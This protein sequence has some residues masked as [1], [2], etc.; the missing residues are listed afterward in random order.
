MTDTCSNR[1]QRDRPSPG[2]NVRPKDHSQFSIPFSDDLII[3][4]WHPRDRQA[5]MQVIST[6][7]SEYGLQWDPVHADHDVIDVEAAYQHGEFWLVENVT[8]AQIVGTAAF[9]PVPKRGDSVVEIRK[10]YLDTSVRRLGLGAFLLSALEQR[11]L[12]LGY[13]TVLV[14]TA[15][16]LK[17]ACILYERRGYLPSTGIDTSRCDR[18]FEKQLLATPSE[19]HDLVEIVDQTRGWSIVSMPRKQAIKYHLPYRA[20]VIQVETN[21]KILVHKRSMRKLTY[22][23]K[24]SAVVTGCVDWGESIHT[25]ACRKISEE[26]GI[27]DLHFYE[28]FQ[29]FLSVADN[30]RGQRILFHPFVATGNFVEEDIVCNPDEVES[31]M[32]LTRDQVLQKKVGGDLWTRFRSYGL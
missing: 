18:V 31:A 28:P 1:G 15:S 10:M 22:A 29:P 16:V 6:T 14:E 23:S 13:H 30:G 20:V 25:A 32:L 24:M 3:R 11:A 26:F 8:T 9:Y 12:Q 7:L 2:T 19:T 27:A 4:A 5:C 21:G 17:E